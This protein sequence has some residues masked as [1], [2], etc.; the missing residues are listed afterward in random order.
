MKRVLIILLL[1][2]LPQIGWAQQAGAVERIA[3][4]LEQEMHSF[5]LAGSGVERQSIRILDSSQLSIPDAS[6]RL[7]GLQRTSRDGYMTTVR[8]SSAAECLPFLVAF[9]CRRP[10]G[11]MT[12]RLKAV[13]HAK[14]GPQAKRSAAVHTGETARLELTLTGA[15]LSFPVIC[16]E[17]GGVGEVIRT[18]G[19]ATNRIFVATVTGPRQLRGVEESQ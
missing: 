5:E 12:D 16:L 17:E 6:F 9:R 19:I 11:A 3:Q 7:A 1:A 14:A 4:L 2:S 8:C 15:N 10:A 13:D 18:R